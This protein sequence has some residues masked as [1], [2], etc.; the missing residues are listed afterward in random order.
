MM[1]IK[2]YEK[3]PHLNSKK[4]YEQNCKILRHIQHVNPHVQHLKDD[5]DDVISVTSVNES[6]TSADSTINEHFQLYQNGVYFNN[7]YY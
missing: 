5:D 4:G 6:V 1:N 3:W 2:E 7:S